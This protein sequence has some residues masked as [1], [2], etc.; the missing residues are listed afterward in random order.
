VSLG[1][2]ETMAAQARSRC[3]EGFEVLKV[4]VGTDPGMTS[5]AS[6]PSPRRW[7]SPRPWP[8]TDVHDLDAG[9]LTGEGGCL[10]YRPPLVEVR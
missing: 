6:G 1:D 10:R 4:K 8:R 2:P 3:A 5:A 9:R 7:R